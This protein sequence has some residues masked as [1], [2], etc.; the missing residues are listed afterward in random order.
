MNGIKQYIDSDIVRK[1]LCN[2]PQIT[3]EITERCCL[4]CI[5][6]GYGSLYANKDERFNN[7]LST[8]KAKILLRYLN[9][10]WKTNFNMCYKHKI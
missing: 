7:D 5:Y 10:L 4:D 9:E 6:C 2:T 8:N 3:F 1:S